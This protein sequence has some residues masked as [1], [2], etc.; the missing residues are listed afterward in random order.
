MFTRFAIKRL[1]MVHFR[2][3]EFH[4]INS[5]ALHIKNGKNI[6]IADFIIKPCIISDFKVTY[7]RISFFKC[8]HSKYDVSTLFWRESAP[9]KVELGTRGV[10][11]KGRRVANRL[12]TAETAGC[13]HWWRLAK[14]SWVGSGLFYQHR[15]SRLPGRARA[16]KPHVH[17]HA[18]APSSK[19]QR[20]VGRACPFSVPPNSLSLT[21]THWTK[22]EM[23]RWFDGGA[24]WMPADPKERVFMDW[25]PSSPEQIWGECE[26]WGGRS[27]G[28]DLGV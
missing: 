18:H 25:S 10:V 4:N 13:L 22:W 19:P 3:L 1:S 12:C 11:V 8:F 28:E 9:F 16:H 17:T 26:R 15:R 20:W 21:R 14:T 7:L 24:A 5:E 2:T 27:C 23:C 6:T